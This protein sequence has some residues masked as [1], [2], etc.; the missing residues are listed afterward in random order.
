MLGISSEN[1]IEQFERPEQLPAYD[2]KD[3]FTISYNRTDPT[4]CRD[5]IDSVSVITENRDTYLVDYNGYLAGALRVT[6]RGMIELGEEFLGNQ[7]D[8]PSWLVHPSSSGQDLPW[9]VPEDYDDQ[10]IFSCQEC[11][12]D[13]T[14]ADIL[15]PGGF[16]TE[17][18]ERVCRDCWDEIRKQ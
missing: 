13:T 1:I 7:D 10:S 4:I 12:T 3:A 2:P 15:T 18:A 6:R 14:A 16:D 11:G 8:I 9:W 5:G 17:V